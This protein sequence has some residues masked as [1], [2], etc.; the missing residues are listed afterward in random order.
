MELTEFAAAT[1]TVVLGSLVQVT[2]GVGAGFIMVP[3]L[4]LIDLSLVPAPLIFGSMSLSIMMA[5]RERAAIDWVH[6]PLIMVGML[7]GAILGAWLIS[8]V[9]LE[10]LGIVFGIV[11]LTAVLVTAY[12]KTLPLSR[13]SALAAGSFAGITS[14]S[15]GIGAPILAL[16]YQHETGSRLRSTLALL[17]TTASAL[18]LLVLAGFNRFG[19]DEVIAGAHLIPGFLVGYAVARRLAARLNDGLT[20]IGV[21]V[22]SALA[23]VALIWRSLPDGLLS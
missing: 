15:A 17:Y 18:V 11:I 5:V 4:A 23:A 20:R 10:Q 8:R 12:G 1:A 2:T 7:P 16:L 21:L 6:I 19:S 3:L 22:V 14:A 13:Y 9:P